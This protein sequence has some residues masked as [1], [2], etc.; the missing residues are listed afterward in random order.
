LAAGSS[1]AVP[2]FGGE[3]EEFF[4]LDNDVSET[5]VLEELAGF[6]NV[7]D[8]TYLLPEVVV[9]VNPLLLFLLGGVAKNEAVETDPLCAEA[10]AEMDVRELDVEFGVAGLDVE[11]RAV[12]IE[13]ALGGLGVAN[14][15]E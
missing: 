5:G 4:V 12:A 2:R 14:L 3:I 7:F 13:E 9:R 15:K 6:G 10:L 11:G 1:E 8:C